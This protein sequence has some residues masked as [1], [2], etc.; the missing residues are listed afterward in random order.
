MPPMRAR[1]I[2]LL[3]AVAALLA[4]APSATAKCIKEHH[5]RIASGTSPNGLP[6]TVEGSIRNN[7]NSCRERLFGMGF[8]LTGVT[9]W[10]W[11]T[12]IPPEATS[13][14]DLKSM[15]PTTFRKMDPPESSADPSAAKWRK[16]WPL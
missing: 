7:G 12:G 3:I 8:E 11:S 15:P 2:L 10:G 5:V 9:N 14:T 13:P 6:W 1:P 16:S 4:F